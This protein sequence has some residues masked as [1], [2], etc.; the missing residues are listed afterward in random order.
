MSKHKNFVKIGRQPPDLTHK[1]YYYFCIVASHNS[2]DSLF[3]IP[4]P[5][6]SKSTGDS[7]RIIYNSFKRLHEIGWIIKGKK[8]GRSREWRVNIQNELVQKSVYSMKHNFLICFRE[9][10]I[11]ELSHLEYKIFC[12]ML[13]QHYRGE[14]LNMNQKKL[15]KFHNVSERMIKKSF[16]VLKEKMYLT[17]VYGGLKIGT[18][19]ARVNAFVRTNRPI[20]TPVVKG[21]NSAA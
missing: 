16:K 15:A 4:Y 3:F 12:Q 18:N 20:E 9:W 14:Q 10:S 13:S 1:Q 19:Y 17:N 2:K 8:F 6:L 7:E 5:K 11:I 21:K